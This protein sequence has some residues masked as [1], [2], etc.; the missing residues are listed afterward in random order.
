M[1]RVVAASEAHVTLSQDGQVITVGNER[2]RAPEVL[3]TPELIGS[4]EPGL[5]EMVF[6]CSTRADLDFFSSQLDVVLSGGSTMFPGMAD[7]LH[8]ELTELLGAAKIATKLKV[9]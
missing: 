1:S 6:D 2:F 7:R 4:E 8:R 9:G 3:F 5:T